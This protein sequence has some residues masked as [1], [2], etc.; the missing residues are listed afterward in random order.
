MTRTD[1][2]ST[3]D[4]GK[5]CILALLAAMAIS[6]IYIAGSWPNQFVY[7]DHEVI[8][9][10][11]PVR[12]VADL[13]QIFRE[14]HYLDFPYYR[15][16]T[17]STFAIQKTIW[18]NR[19]R[20]YHIFNG[21]LAGLV[22][23]AAYALLCRP[24]L[25]LTPTTALLAAIW[26]ALHPALSE[27][28]Y[29]AASGRETLLPAFFMLLTLW[30]YLGR[31]KLDYWLAITF[32]AI[33]LL[34]KEQAAVMPGI[35]VLAD[36]LGFTAVS[37][38]KSRLPQWLRR[39]MPM[40]VLF[41]V[42][43]LVRH[44]IFAQSALHVNV[45]SHPMEP[46]YSLL[47]GVQTGI[48]PYVQLRYEPTFAVWFDSLLTS[49]ALVVLVVILAGVV[50]AGNPVRRVALL[51][52]GWFVLLQLPTAHILR[53]QEAPYS[54]RYAALAILAIPATAVI[55]LAPR[56]RSPRANRMAFFGCLCWIGA[57]G[58][59]SYLRGAFYT[60]DASFSATWNETNP[61]APG[62]YIGMGL[63]AQQ[64]HDYETA[65]HAYEKA[66]E[67]DPNSNSA[68]NNLANLLT[69]MGL[70][71]Q[72]AAHFQWLLAN[73]RQDTVVVMTNYAQMLGTEAY[74]THNVT[75][76]FWARDMLN[77]AIRM[78]PK[79][80]QA[81]YV[82]GLWNEAFGTRDEAIKE[83]KTA[84]KL[85][86]DLPDAQNQINKL[87]AIKPSPEKAATTR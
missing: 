7:D 77:D 49:V 3:S 34:C 53:E 63:V 38:D 62:A 46:L 85:R 4:C 30:A 25:L 14:P 59:V 84:L 11:Y 28:V 52:L 78:R 56:L 19:P 9:N 22:M 41:V 26:F 29:P 17:R 72:A 68:H 10:Q 50:A 36:L 24:A 67:L 83:F 81:H 32:F 39:W 73:N 8:E 18:G 71:R 60:D 57:F 86:P 87:E 79:Y 5:H 76:H 6:A 47:Y 27:C 64:K 55:A 65:R 43:F 54:E 42:Y 51:W 21:L 66:V 82:L 44:L 58:W 45:F 74:A 37:S 31:E 33:S 20:P 69:D 75:L 15:P 13:A 35:L 80:A 16:I 2:K 1:C 61:S 12:H 23:L 70:Y 40:A 48:A